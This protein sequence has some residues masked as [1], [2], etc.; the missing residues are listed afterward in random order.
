MGT[1][2]DANKFCVDLIQWEVA[3]ENFILRNTR[4]HIFTYGALF[5]QI[6]YLAS[7]RKVDSNL[8]STMECA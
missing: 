6:S 1:I 5:Q 2:Y 8:D 4:N 3:C 7:D